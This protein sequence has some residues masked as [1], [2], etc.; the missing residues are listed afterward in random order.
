MC[1]TVVQKNFC[2]QQITTRGYAFENF[3]LTKYS[4]AFAVT[5]KNQFH[6]NDIPFFQ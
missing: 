6:E 5:M 4:T 3:C 2:K 1:K